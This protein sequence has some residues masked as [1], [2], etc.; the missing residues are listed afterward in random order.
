MSNTTQKLN[1]TRKG[2]IIASVSVFVALVVAL[3]P[4]LSRTF[5]F[6]GTEILPYAPFARIIRI[7]SWDTR[8]GV[9]VNFDDAFAVIYDS[10]PLIQNGTRRIHILGEVESQPHP[11]RPDSINQYDVLLFKVDG[12]IIAVRT[13]GSISPSVLYSWQTLDTALSVGNIPFSN[14]T[15]VFNALSTYTRTHAPIL[16]NGRRYLARHDNVTSTPAI[17]NDW[18]RVSPHWINQSYPVG[19]LVTHAGAHFRKISTLDAEPGTNPTIWEEVPF[20]DR[21][22]FDTPLWYNRA[23]NLHDVVLHHGV[24]FVSLANNNTALT[25]N[26]AFWQ[27]IIAHD[28]STTVPTWTLGTTFQVGDFVRYLGGT[29]ERF[30]TLTLAWGA[31]QSPIGSPAWTE[32]FNFDELTAVIPWSATTTYDASW[33]GRLIEYQGF[34]FQSVGHSAAGITPLQ[35]PSHFR[36][37]LTWQETQSPIVFTGS[38]AGVHTA[39]RI[40]DVRHID[41]PGFFA[42]ISDAYATH[43]PPNFDTHGWWRRVES[44]DPNRVYHQ[45]TSN[46]WNVERRYHV[47]TFSENGERIFWEVAQA[48]ASG[49]VG[50]EPNDNSPH[51]RRFVFDTSNEELIVT[52]VNNR[53]VVW[54]RNTPAGVVPREPSVLNPDWSR[55]VFP[56]SDSFVYTINNGSR[57][58]WSRDTLGET[59]EIPGFGD[60]WTHRP[61]RTGISFVYTVNSV[62]IHMFWHSSEQSNAHP[63]IS[64]ADWQLLGEALH[65]SVPAFFFMVNDGEVFYFEQNPYGPWRRHQNAWHGKVGT[66]MLNYWYQ[67]NSYQPGDIVVYGTTAT[68]L[69][70]F[71]RMR[72][73]INTRLAVGISPMS[74][75]G[76]AFWEAI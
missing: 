47:Y 36:R 39:T 44:F 43:N 54:E 71:F 4:F 56:V 41:N 13:T 26:T 67:H 51:W 38:L 23:W 45:F 1:K 46:T 9:V 7:G 48:P 74:N 8:E 20:V 6:W 40:F 30:F 53:P 60:V 55:R 24:F 63:S 69:N 14:Q 21:T 3:L 72:E 12:I 29:E 18:F 65:L 73:G 17:G 11:N 28:P 75:A 2:V 27:E 25:T 19:S 58:L 32:V 50:I 5:A 37:I 33:L 34:I 70:R 10:D 16:F 22:I 62:G 52:S 49:I 31:T 61:F 66:E 76:R 57:T 42:L 64:S 59:S 15:N 68:N 35:N